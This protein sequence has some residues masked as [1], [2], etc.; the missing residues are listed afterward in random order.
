MD[1][2]QVKANHKRDLAHLAERKE[3][4]HEKAVV[5]VERLH[6]E[7]VRKLYD[8]MSTLR[9]EHENTKEKMQAGMSVLQQVNQKM[10]DLIAYSQM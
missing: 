4:E 9:K 3:L 5:E 10:N 6:N 1:F 8:E 7:E 2:K